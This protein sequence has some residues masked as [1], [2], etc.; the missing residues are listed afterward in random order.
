M[1]S[2]ERS[3]PVKKNDRKQ[4]LDKCGHFSH[5]LPKITYFFFTHPLDFIPLDFS[6]IS[7]PPL[8]YFPRIFLINLPI[9]ETTLFSRPG[10][11]KRSQKNKSTFPRVF[12]R[13]KSALIQFM[14]PYSAKNRCRIAATCARVALPCG[15]R[16][17]AVMPVI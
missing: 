14:S 13:E 5:I 10:A 17:S 9:A 2:G 1:H 4:G 16:V 12:L 3:S 11:R 6:L 7:Y 15:W 8:F